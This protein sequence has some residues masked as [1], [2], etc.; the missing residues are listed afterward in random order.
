MD[1]IL[2][3][4]LFIIFL[5]VITGLYLYNDII[6]RITEVQKRSENS[7]T[8]NGTTITE[9]KKK[10][11]EFDI[12][13][14]TINKKVDTE[15][16]TIKNQISTLNTEIDNHESGIAYQKELSTNLQT[17]TDTLNTQAN[18]L[19][20]RFLTLEARI[21]PLENKTKYMTDSPNKTTV[22]GPLEL[23]PNDS[24]NPTLTSFPTTPIVYSKTDGGGIYYMGPKH[25]A[26][27]YSLT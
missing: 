4:K 8:P 15:L 14:S 18:S 12:S 26:V 10:L 25:P 21:S 17:I 7:L 3:T 11:E 6:V 16:N 1:K 22:L 27:E 24:R 9:F 13:L 5:I 19:S 2:F 20:S 23:L